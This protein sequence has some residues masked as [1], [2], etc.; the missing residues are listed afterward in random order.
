MFQHKTVLLRET[1][2][3]LNIKPDGTY[4]DCTLGGAG[5]STYLLQQLSEKGRLIAF[6]QDDT[7]LQHAEETLS[8]YQGQLILIKSNFRYLKECLHE[9]GITEVD[10]ILFDL[11]VSSPQLDTPER[12]FSYHHDAPLD[13]RMDQSATLTAKEVVNE[14]RYEDL[15]RIFFKY[16][17]EKFSKQIARKI[18]EARSKSPI[19]TTG[20]L[21]DLIKDAIPAPARRSGGHPA[22]RVFQA[23]RIAVNDELKVFEEALEQ[24]IDV[25]KPGGRV[26]VITFHSLEDRICKSTFKEKS[27][28]P[29]L[30][31]GLPVIPEEFEPELKLITR[32]PITASEEE[33][34]ENNR[35]RSAK[36]RIAEKR[37]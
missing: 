35:A 6:D 11:G 37:K 26:S 7:A 30:P 34:A 3:G 1:V 29:E 32:K 8:D 23:I 31:P 17:E 21:V 27:S 15:V 25:L 24:A 33:L 2:D 4:V 13:M 12:G 20:Q 16:G 9:H 14:W 10:G 19:Q 36:L 28:L 5:H 18:E 22:K